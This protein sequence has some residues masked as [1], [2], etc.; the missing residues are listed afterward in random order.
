MKI[1]IFILKLIFTLILFSQNSFA[2]S[3]PPGAGASDVP[4]NVLILLDVSGSMGDKMVI[5]SSF[6]RPRAVAVDTNGNIYGPTKE[7]GS[8]KKVNI[9]TEQIDRSF[10]VNGTFFA[11]DKFTCYYGA[12]PTSMKAH[13]GYLYVAA[14]NDYVF[15]INLTT[16]ICDDWKEEIKDPR[17]IIIKNNILYVFSGS[18]TR[19]D[20]SRPTLTIDL[21]TNTKI[22]CGDIRFRNNPSG[23]SAMTIDASGNNLY[24]YDA[25]SLDPISSSKRDKI[26][27]WEI[28]PITKCFNN[29]PIKTLAYEDQISTN[30]MDGSMIR[31]DN[32]FTLGMEAHPT[33]DNILYLSD[34]T[35]RVVYKLTL[36]SEKD[37]ATYEHVDLGSYLSSKSQLYDMDIDRINKRVMIGDAK[38]KGSTL[39]LDYNLEFIKNMGESSGSGSRLDGALE[40]I[41]AVVTDSSLTAGVD[42][43]FGIWNSKGGRYGGW[44][45]DI[46][47]GFAVPCP[48]EG[49]LKVRVHKKGAPQINKI[50]SSIEVTGGTSATSFAYLAKNY[51]VESGDDSPIDYN[52]PCQNTYIINIGDGD[53]QDHEDAVLEIRKLYNR[54]K[55]KVKTFSVAYGGEI[56][57]I[58]LMQF[59][60]M[61][62]AG[63]TNNVIIAN[64]PSSLKSQLKSAI[65]QVIAS[66]LSFTA[67]AITSEIQSGGSLFQAQFDYVQNQQWSGTLKKTAISSNGVLDENNSSNWD[68][69]DQMP[70]PNNRKIW[71]VIQGLD[72]KTDYNNFTDTNWKKIN[73]LFQKTN[74]V[75]SNYHSISNNPI[76]SQR[77]KN[78][79]GVENGNE[80]DI[81]GLINFVRGQDYFDYD[82]DCDLTEARDNPL[83]DIYHSELVTVGAPNA[84]TAFTGKNQEAYFRSINNYDTWAA[85]KSNREEII[86]VGANDGML[87]A[88]NAKTGV[89]EWAFVPPFIASSMPTMIN[90]NLNQTF[91]GSNAIYGVDGSPVVHDMYFRSAFDSAKQWHTILMIPYGRG[92]AGFSVL[93]ITDPYKPLHLYSVLNDNIRNEVHVMDHNGSINSYDYIASSYPLRSLVEA[94]Q[95]RENADNDVG[96]E[97]C[98]NSGNDRCYKAKKWTLPPNLQNVKAS[99]LTVILDDMEYTSFSIGTHTSGPQNGRTFIQFKD[100]MT[101]YGYDSSSQSS[102]LGISIK[103]GS[104]LTGVQTQREYDYSSLG[105][106]WSSPRIIRLPN[107][108]ARDNLID[109]DIYVAVMGGGYGVQ[110]SGLGSNL[111]IVNLEDTTHPGKI[112]KVIPIEDLETN[113]IVNSTPGSPVVITPDTAI[114]ANYKGAIVYLSDLEGKITKFNLTN[115]DNDGEGNSIALYDSTTLFTAGSNSINGRYMYHSMDATIGQSTNSLWLYA[116]TGDYERIADTSPGIQNLMLGIADP[117]FPMY[118]EL[119]SPT[120]ASDLTKCKNTTDDTT[121]VNCPVLNNDIG[122]YINLPD[123]QKVTAEP[124]IANG[125]SYFPVYRPSAGS[126]GCSIGDAFICANDDECG[127]NASSSLGTFQD[128]GDKCLYVGKGVLTKIVFFKD[129]LFANIAGESNQ[130]IK[131]LVTLDIP[132]GDITGYRGSW[133]EN[134]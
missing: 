127:T 80:D 44:S 101:Y 45:G 110:H 97:V 111:T 29:L 2:K 121:G 103:P 47:D 13:N 37:N 90:V 96:N 69:T 131:D 107:S 6:Y 63:G 70:T 14:D 48:K 12:A 112:E 72:Y 32:T 4:S 73:Q 126:D 91:G 5:E 113:D 130:N 52:L 134:F 82:G 95:V 17:V 68:A 94:I 39:V 18:V 86:Y 81:K 36:N 61:A 62:M 67:P 105:E 79:S 84:E 46:T 71:T 25:G 98:N 78:T 102:N 87:H 43:G 15:R 77:C 31:I 109:D 74:N 34:R 51:L 3:L 66:K 100:K 119:N 42:F 129:K 57:P 49:C 1:K 133:R 104:V 60:E 132:A 41:K 128:P 65:S 54:K 85:S 40:A 117:D 19:K 59:D 125:L 122:W 88:F 76:N 7:G 26:Q 23:S 93:D 58:G 55:G 123:A 99:D 24:G 89:E 9:D 120:K 50:L 11:P 33:D 108:G 8:I 10:G 115:M 118:K 22:D 56:S 83:G 20:N 28:D 38:K 106:T 64:S 114:S 53:W 27:R 92:G 124:S 30:V 116:G 16:G 21:S 35:N 75:V